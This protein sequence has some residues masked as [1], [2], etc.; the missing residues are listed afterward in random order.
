MRSSRVLCFGLALGFSSVELSAAVYTVTTT[1]EFEPAFA[2]A[3]ASDSV[4][5]EDF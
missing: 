3:L 5:P 2:A 4:L 1:A